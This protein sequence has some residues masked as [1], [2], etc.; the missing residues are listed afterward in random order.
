MI[1]TAFSFFY[2]K[3]S[4][5]VIYLEKICDLLRLQILQVPLIILTSILF[6]GLTFSNIFSLTVLL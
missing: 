4:A 6:L 3:F 2:I 5:L 1:F